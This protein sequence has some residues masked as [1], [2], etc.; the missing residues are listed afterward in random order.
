MK[1]AIKILN[2][3]TCVCFTIWAALMIICLIYEG[4]LVLKSYI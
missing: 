4:I 2:I 1:K 3:F